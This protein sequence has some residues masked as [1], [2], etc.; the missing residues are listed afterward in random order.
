MRIDGH[1]SSTPAKVRRSALTRDASWLAPDAR[2]LVIANGMGSP[3]LWSGSVSTVCAAV[4]RTLEARA[5]E[6][7]RVAFETAY[8]EARKA[9][10]EHSSGAIDQWSVD[11]ALLIVRLLD[12]KIVA[13]TA[14]PMRVYLAGTAAPKRLS[15][16]EADKGILE[17]SSNVSEATIARG[18]IVLAGSEDAFSVRGVARLGKVIGDNPK[19]RA[20]VLASLLTEPARDAGVA[21][22]AAAIR[23]G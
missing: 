16:R 1:V 8:H 11:V 2:T 6:E 21:A 10:R 13:L 22:V 9:L 7:T 12:D 4:R 15:P 17:G 3:R 14:G 18:D 5:D 19:T 23:I 20:Q